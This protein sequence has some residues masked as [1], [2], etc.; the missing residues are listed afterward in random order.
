M[1]GLTSHPVTTFAAGLAASMI[2][3]LNAFL[4]WQTLL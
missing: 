2:I 3:A 1:A 4:L